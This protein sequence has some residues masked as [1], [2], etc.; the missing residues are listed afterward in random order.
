MSYVLLLGL[1][2]F[3]SAIGA[4]VVILRMHRF[5]ARARLLPPESGCGHETQTAADSVLID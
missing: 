2:L 1:A 3:S 4:L 5:V